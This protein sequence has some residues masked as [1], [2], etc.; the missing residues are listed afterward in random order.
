VYEPIIN[1]PEGFLPEHHYAT[2]FILDMAT[3]V[4]TI[5]LYFSTDPIDFQVSGSTSLISPVD[6]MGQQ[7]ID[8]HFGDVSP[9]STPGNG[10]RCTI[11]I[12]KTT[13]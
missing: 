6:G 5:H 9:S 10:S 13:T 4:F 8:P 12:T 3:G 1:V 7:S 2:E 11:T